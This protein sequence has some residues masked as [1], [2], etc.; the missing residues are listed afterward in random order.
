MQQFFPSKWEVGNRFEWVLD[1]S[2]DMDDLRNK[3]TEKTGCKNIALSI[4]DRQESIK[5]INIPNLHW[6]KP[7]NEEDYDDSDDDHRF[8]NRSSRMSN[9]VRLLR[10]RDSEIVYFYDVSEKLKDLNDTEKKQINSKDMAIRN[11]FSSS[12]DGG[13]EESLHIKQ[14]EIEIDI[15]DTSNDN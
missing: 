3:I 11:R 14:A 6:L 1:V 7:K 4:G 12:R 15:K 10:A 9:S 8:T 13:K 5:F 2:E